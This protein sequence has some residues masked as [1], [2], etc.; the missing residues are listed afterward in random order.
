MVSASAVIA[1]QACILTLGRSVDAFDHVR[2]ILVYPDRYWAPDTWEDESGIVTEELDDRDGEAWEWCSV[3]LSWQQVLADSRTLHGR[4]LVLHELAHQ[5]DLLDTIDQL[6]RRV[7]RGLGESLSSISDTDPPLVQYT[8]SS[9]EALRLLALGS[10]EWEAGRTAEAER[11]YLLALEE[12]KYIENSI[13]ISS[14]LHT[15]ILRF[16]EKLTAPL[17]NVTTSVSRAEIGRASCRE[18][19]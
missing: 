13:G 14:D 6:T 16:L 12:D 8:T 2:S 4:N 18:R 5:L 9:W 1:A 10:K 7:R 17:S 19:V 3:V 11:C 15:I